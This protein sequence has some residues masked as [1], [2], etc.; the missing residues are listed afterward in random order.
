MHNTVLITGAS[1]G[2]GKELAYLYAKDAKQLILVARNESR[3]KEV[4][5][6]VEKHGAKA[7]IISQD[8][9]EPQSAQL[10]LEKIKDQAKDIEVLINNAGF[11]DIGDFSNADIDKTENM[12]Q[13]N[14]NTLTSLTRL[15][16]PHMINNNKGAIM[17]VAST[18]AFQP[19]PYMAVYFATKAYVLSLSEALQAELEDKGVH[20]MALCPGPTDTH[21]AETANDGKNLSFFKNTMDAKTVAKLAKEGMEKKKAIVITGTKNRLTTLLPK[22]LPRSVV[23]KVMK[24]VLK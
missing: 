4:A 10:L 6:E 24:G 20:V 17:N 1:S 23:R 7:T 9:A 12:M 2:I 5:E 13:L 11:G 18:A 3:L 21:F 19:G 8:L 15:I 14:M 22:L 16:V